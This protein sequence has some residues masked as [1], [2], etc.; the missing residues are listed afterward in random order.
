MKVAKWSGFV[1]KYF[2]PM[3][4]SQDGLRS[5][6]FNT[7]EFDLTKFVQEDLNLILFCVLSCF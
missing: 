3:G 6:I 7:V 2:H 4:V 5:L 1:M